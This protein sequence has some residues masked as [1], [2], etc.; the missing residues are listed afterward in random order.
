MCDRQLRYYIL[1]N[2]YVLM[3]VDS[4]W[5]HRVLSSLVRFCFCFVVKNAVIYSLISAHG[6]V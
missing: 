4:R 1:S 6:S 2:I 5:F 3:L